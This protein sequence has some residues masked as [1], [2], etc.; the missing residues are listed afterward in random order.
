MCLS[1]VC[2]WHSS[3]VILDH[4]LLS[5]ER[6]HP[7]SHLLNHVAPRCDNDP[8]SHPYARYCCRWLLTVPSL[9]LELQSLL[10]NLKLHKLSEICPHQ[11]F[12][13]G[14]ANLCFKLKVGW[15]CIELCRQNSDLRKEV[16]IC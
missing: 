2:F 1:G 10:I 15:V 4:H 16:G 14:L 3:A 7:V 13:T 12:L 8:S 9:S 5:A 11:G 6:I